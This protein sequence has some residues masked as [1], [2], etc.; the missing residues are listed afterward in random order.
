MKEIVLNEIKDCII[1]TG[2]SSG[3]G[4]EIYNWF[5]NKN[6]N[7]SG[8]GRRG[9]DWTIDLI[10]PDA[11]KVFTNYLFKNNYTV[12]ILINNAGVMLLDESDEEACRNMVELNLIAVWDLMKSFYDK[13]LLVEG[14]QVINIASIS[15]IKGDSDVPL[16]SATKAGV[17]ALTKAFAKAWAKDGIRVNS[18]SP[19]L[20]DTNLAPPPIPQE[21]ID[22]IPM[23]RSA[24][25]SELIPILEGI[26][27][28]NYMTGSNIVI[29]GGSLL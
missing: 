19:G 10:N 3:I 25:T 15:G 14:S 20:F 12:K 11:R 26:L 17:I 7:I 24:Q 5:S 2:A 16:Y 9:P 13:K 18:I 29:D 27:N 1:V 8:I 21:L 28:S 23:K 4:K 22:S 6:V